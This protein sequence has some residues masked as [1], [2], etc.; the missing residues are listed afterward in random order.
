[1]AGDGSTV[2]QRRAGAAMCFRN[3]PDAAPIDY[4]TIS[5][6]QAVRGSRELCQ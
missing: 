6:R 2:D 1:M 4:C 5:K 3:P